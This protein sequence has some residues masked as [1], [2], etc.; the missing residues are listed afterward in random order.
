MTLQAVSVSLNE[1]E[2][3][4]RLFPDA[5]GSQKKPRMIRNIDKSSEKN[6]LRN[7]VRD[8]PKVGDSETISCAS[9]A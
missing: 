6:P 1:V 4:I 9:T 7:S 3:R 8:K 5:K 2:G